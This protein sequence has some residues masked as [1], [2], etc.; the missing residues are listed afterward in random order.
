MNRLAGI[1]VAVVGL[2]LT[3][4]SV[5]KV[6]AGL[7]STGILLLLLG[8]LIIG[9]S[10]IPKTNSNDT[11]RMSTA[12][13]LAGIFYAPAEV[14]Q[15]LRRH[16]RWLVAVLIMSVLS[17]IY[18]NA[19]MYRL[20]PDRVANYAIDKTLEMSFI[21]NN[22]DAKKGVE[23]GRAQ[24]IADNKSP[25][26]RAGQ[27]VNGFVWQVFL[28]A[29][30]GAVFFVFALAM[31]GQMS[32]WQSFSAAVYAGF[33]LAVIKFVLN[34]IVLFIKD[35]TDIHP[36]IGQSSLIQ[37][38]LNFLVAPAD[39]PVLYVLLS[40]FSLLTLYWVWLNATGLKNTGD[41]VSPSIA[42]SATLTI[43]GVMILLGVVSALLFPS[44]IS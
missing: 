19:F 23:A 4:L 40:S 32:Y 11:P 36:I 8:I 21:A 25:I 10:F 28:Y 2:L 9:L 37:D 18:L 29:F 26:L 24:A 20:T 30:L 14:F 31:G 39:N 41:K 33:P 44:F 17:A 38:S 34:T 22:E 1:I 7:T 16:P 6:T 15:N 43:F 35:P 42:W 5:A 27:A 13:T 3:G 12:E